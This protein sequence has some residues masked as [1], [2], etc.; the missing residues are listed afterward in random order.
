[1]YGISDTNA[2]APDVQSLISKAN[3]L[4]LIKHLGFQRNGLY[5]TSFQN[6]KDLKFTLYFIS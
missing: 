6:I 4:H 5:S 1:M 3:D 2:I